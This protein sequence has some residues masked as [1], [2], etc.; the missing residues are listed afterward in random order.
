[1]PMIVGFLAPLAGASA[2]T[3]AFL[4]IG[5]G[6]GLSFLSRKINSKKAQSASAPTGIQGSLQLDASTPRQVLFGT[7]VPDGSLHYWQLS[8]ENNA[9]LQMVVILVD[10]ECDSLTGLYVDTVL[11]SW[12]PVTGQVDG[13]GPDLIVKFYSGAP[14][15]TAASEIVVNSGGRW[16]ADD[17][18]T[19]MCYATISCNYVPEKFPNGIPKITF[20]V[21]GAKLYDPRFDS[22]AGGSGAQ[23]WSNPAT[24]VWT[25]NAATVEYNV[26]RGFS[27]G[28]LPLLGMRVP[29]AAIR[30]SDYVSAA[31]SCDEA[32]AKKAG[33][34]EARYRINKV[35]NTLQSNREILETCSGAMA[36]EL[37]ESGGIYRIMAG[38]TQPV[39]AALSD[40][41]LV[42]KKRY[43]VDPK[44]PRSRL[45]NAIQATFTDPTHGYTQMPLP[46]RLSSADEAIDGG[47]VGP[48][49]LTK[50]LDLT[51]VTSRSQAQ[52]VMEIERKRA[53]RQAV[54]EVTLVAKWFRLEPGDWITLSST[55]RFLPSPTFEVLQRR[56]AN[57][58]TTTVTLGEV[59][60]AID[61]FVAATDEINDDQVLDLLSAGPP[62]NTVAGF[63][64]ANVV[65]STGSAAS[66]PALRATWIPI[67]DQTVTE[68]VIE[69]RR[70]GDAVSQEK[71]VSN[72][73]AG[74][75]IW[76]SGVQGG[77]IYEAQ[78]IAVATPARAMSWSG[79][80]SAGAAT[81]PQVVQVA[82]VAE[83]IA[84]ENIPPAELSAQDKFL[85]GLSAALG[86]VQGSVDDRLLDIIADVQEMALSQLQHRQQTGETRARILVE[87]QTR[88]TLSES[89]GSYSVMVDAALATITGDVLGTS[90]AV[91]SLT[92]RVTTV[93][94]VVD[95]NSAAIT[96]VEAT[97][98][99]KATVTAVNSLTTRVTTAEGEITTQGAAVTGLQSTVGGHTN[100][101]NQ[102]VALDG[103]NKRYALVFDN[104]G[105]AV[106]PIEIN[107]NGKLLTMALA[108]SQL[109]IYDPGLNG[110]APIQMFTLQTINGQVVA[111]LN[112]TFIAHAFE[113]GLITALKANLTEIIGGLF[114]N[115]AN[116]SYW[117]TETGDLQVG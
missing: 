19:G 86:E 75:A 6:V 29:A 60:S 85:A 18:C 107:G 28:G 59:D 33:G 27:S 51:A 77:A 106:S 34:T 74:A 96:A 37:I 83:Y 103:V 49:R 97:L 41:D 81:A 20:I 93:E 13:Y 36:G 21:K 68:L 2:L 113:A 117:N 24:W 3:T 100:S 5:A 61:D 116:T 54:V 95:A 72:P 44:R 99:G 14:G 91:N 7:A 115:E 47:V 79:W 23:R 50:T 94:G 104:N 92:T 63:G 55:R 90:N 39:V 17:K 65:M 84:P 57:D 52:R 26:L 22:T 110:G 70:V 109:K 71:R 1:M 88:Q 45:T 30:F 11:K 98:P 9:L 111:A 58:L 16:T 32:V 42:V 46:P 56:V 82:A 53:R 114:R 69:Y 31:N 8:G 102:I 10:H 35:F 80:Q 78:A 101:I 105:K 62:L 4:Q 67:L 66:A 43:T 48:I 89:F 15:Q 12:D 40:A 108:L 112:G 38:V 64:I 87:E 25:D 76:S 73:A